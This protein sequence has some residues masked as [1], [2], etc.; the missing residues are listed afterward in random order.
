MS[1]KLLLA[2]FFSVICRCESVYGSPDSGMIVATVDYIEIVEQS[3][4][5]CNIREK[6]QNLMDSIRRKIEKL[7]ESVRAA[8]T[9]N[10]NSNTPSINAV[11]DNRA[12]FDPE[13][14]KRSSE[15]DRHLMIYSLAQKKSNE[16]SA[17]AAKSQKALKEFIKSHIRKIANLKGID[18]V[19]D[20]SAVAYKNSKVSDITKDVIA[21]VNADHKKFVYPE[22]LE[23]YQ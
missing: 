5:G 7:E 17:I 1:K 10:G 22:G 19:L 8:S 9:Q 3:K 15:K 13:V 11:F 2:T 6:I 20:K 16:V 18:V 14:Y 4:V 23:K 21:S 12:E